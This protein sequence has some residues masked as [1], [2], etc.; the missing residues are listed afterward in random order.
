MNNDTDYGKYNDVNNNY[1]DYGDYGDYDNCSD[2]DDNCC[3]YDYDDE[4]YNDDESENNRSLR[5]TK[6]HVEKYDKV[7]EF[8]S[9]IDYVNNNIDVNE[10]EDYNID[11]DTKADSKDNAV[12]ATNTASDNIDDDAALIDNEDEK[13]LNS[14]EIANEFVKIMEYYHSDSEWKNNQ[15]RERACE[16]MQNFIYSIIHKRY[17]TYTHQYWSDLCQAGYIGVLTALEKY[18]PE[19]GKPSTYFYRHIIHEMQA[20]IDQEVNK[21]TPHY[22]ANT[23]KVDKAIASFEANGTPYTQV[24]IAIQT[25]LSVETVNKVLSMKNSRQEVHSDAMPVSCLEAK[26]ENHD[27]K[28]P[29][30]ELLEKE[31]YATLY[32]AMDEILTSEEKKVI[33]YS[34]G[35]YGYKTLSNKAIAEKL[36][37]P[38][39]KVR[40]LYSSTLKKLRLS[41]MKYCLK[42]YLEENASIVKNAEIA[43]LPED[44]MIVRYLNDLEC[45]D[46]DF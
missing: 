11:L 43:V 29:E 1:G 45:V 31:K 10:N 41:N 40:K 3:D 19:K 32:E 38:I 21:M 36:H 13:V 33:A 9:D 34:I 42:D 24:D 26:L 12:D 39:D 25:N 4:N 15:A 46:I 30:E 18:D 20:F 5:K 23:R 6:K 22:S 37:M 7:D 35:L 28:T 27:T 44:D 14:D 8:D 17:R 2:N 16:L